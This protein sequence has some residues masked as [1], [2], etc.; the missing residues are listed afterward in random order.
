V[1]ARPLERVI[2]ELLIAPVAA[3]IVAD[4][5]LRERDLVVEAEGGNIVLR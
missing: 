4:A 1:G 3:R 2:E 5:G